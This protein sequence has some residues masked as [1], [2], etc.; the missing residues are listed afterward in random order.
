MEEWFVAPIMEKLINTGFQYLGDQ[1]R[2]QTGMKEE[3]ER[4]RENH[5]KIQAVVDFAS[6]QEQIRDRNPALNEWLWQLRD[7]IDEADDVLDDLEYMK[8]EKQ[9]AKDKK[10]RKVRSIMKSINKRLVQIGKRALKIDPNL[11]R[12]EKVVQKLD[13]VSA[14]VATFLHL[15][16]DAKQEHQEQQLEMYRARETGSLPKNDLIGRG[17][18]KDFVM[19]WLRNPSNE[20]QTTLYSNIS[21]LSIV[22]QGGMGKTTLLQHV[23]KDEITKE[24]DLKMRICVSNNF[25][26][27]RVIA[28]MLE[29]LKNERTQLETLDAL[30]KSLQSMVNSKK[31]LLVLDDIWNDDKEQDKNKWENVLAPLASGK[32]G[33]KILLT[34]RMESVAVMISNVMKKKNEMLRLD[35]LKDEECLLLLLRYAFVNV[36]TFNAHHNLLP[37]TRKIVKKLSGSP[38]A[39]R[40]IGG[41]LN[42]HLDESHWIRVLNHDIGS[43]NDIFSVLKLSYIFLPKVL[44]NCLSFCSIFPQ[45]HEFDKDDLVRMWIALG[46]IQPSNIG[47]ETT[48]DAGERYFNVLVKKSLF[49]KFQNKH[50]TFYKLHDLLHEMVRFVSGQEY[51]SIIGDEELFIK[52][53][54]TVRHLY[55]DTKNIDVFRNMK[56]FKKLRSLIVNYIWMVSI[57]DELT[58]IFKTLKSLRLMCIHSPLEEIPEEI[59][60]LTHLRYL[61]FVKAL[62]VPLPRSVCNLY[63]L[64]FLIYDRDRKFSDDDDFLPSDLNNLRNLHYLELSS[65][66]MYEIGK[67]NSLQELDGIFVQNLAGYRIE[68]LENMNE[69]RKLVIYFPENVEDAKDACKAKLC[70]K[71]NLTD[72]SIEWGSLELI[73]HY[74][75]N[76]LDNLQPHSCLKKLKINSFKGARSAIWMNNVHLISNLEYI[77]LEDCSAWKTL[78]PFWQLPFLKSLYLHDMPEVKGFDYKFHEN[79]KIRV[80]PSLEVLHIHKLKAMEDWFI[81]TAAAYECLFPCLTKLC[82]EDCPNLLE[83]PSCP[84]KL[85]KLEINNIGWKD[86][87]WLQGISNYCNISIRNCQNLNYPR[88]H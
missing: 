14:G 3:L 31:F 53:P 80:F 26:V 85:E 34:T 84:P 21:L 75:E 57:F 9:L 82:L 33:S 12:L 81:A 13:R 44:Q 1:V 86:C 56:K 58:E 62:M 25:D 20:Y 24:F 11:K 8:L 15:V 77:R 83:L 28:N 2:W 55:V 64:Q 68:E 65:P 41:V 18:D 50:R 37:T 52:N 17:K 36:E 7:A 48:K 54:E 46:F 87:N 4:L 76:V 22:G 38:L 16:K 51:F 60:Y 35:G 32:F 10:Q 45:D 30:Q 71:R 29:S 63:H 67:L 49:D 27:N 73:N 59:G 79:D 69:L 66:G 42:S 47:G 43:Q 72:L 19:K 88:K 6:S 40:V 78:P 61:N 23:Y 5:P 70:D 39:A 74:H